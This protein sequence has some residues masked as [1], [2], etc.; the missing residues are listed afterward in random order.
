MNNL[1]WIKLKRDFDEQRCVLLIGPS[2]A[3]VEKDGQ[4]VPMAEELS[5]YLA[6][7]LDQEKVEYDQNAKDKLTYI[8]L[9]FLSIKGARRVDLEDLTKDFIQQNCKKIP[10]TYQWLAKLPFNIFINTNTDDYMQR[11]LREEGKQPLD[12]YYNFRRD[13]ASTIDFDKVNAQNPLVYNLFGAMTET[14]SLVITEDDQLEFIRNIV[15]DDPRIPEEIL[16]QFDDRKTYLFFGFNLENWQFRLLL[17]GLKLKEENTTISP[18]ASRYPMSAITK[19][20]YEERFSFQFI[21]KE[22]KDFLAELSSKVMPEKEKSAH[23]TESV[24]LL[25]NE[26]DETFKNELENNLSQLVKNGEINLQYPERFMAGTEDTEIKEALKNAN[27]ILPILS[28]NFLADT[29]M[30]DHLLPIAAELDQNEQAKLRPIIARPCD[31]RENPSLRTKI[32][33]PE[34]GEAITSNHWNTS[35]DAYFNIVQSLKKMLK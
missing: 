24:F 21:D 4:M 33:L 18:T 5:K 2:L 19:S 12:L 30:A 23:K 34:N 15:K 8:A 6:D 9:R 20:F 3:E 25:Y 16:G 31:W 11:A 32:P 14:E 13:T 1:Q 28:P 35:D 17:D 29:E 27:I 10:E 26:K 7:F 22:A